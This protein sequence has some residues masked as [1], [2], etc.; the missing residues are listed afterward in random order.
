M[1]MVVK[2]LYH[3]IFA[4][5]FFRSTLSVKKSEKAFVKLN[6]NNTQIDIMT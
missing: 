2:I 3:N 5:L 1:I 6:P 4:E